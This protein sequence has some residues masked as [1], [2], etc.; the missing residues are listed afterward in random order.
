MVPDARFDRLDAVLG[1]GFIRVDID[2]S[3]GNP[4]GN[5]AWAHSVVTEDLVDEEGHPTRDALD[6]V[7]DLFRERLLTA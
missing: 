5:S 4:H 1:E 6:Q 7:L 3:K 2:S